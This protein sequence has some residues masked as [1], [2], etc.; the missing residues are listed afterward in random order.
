MGAKMFRLINRK[1]KLA[2]SM[3]RQPHYGYMNLN[4][5]LMKFAFKYACSSERN[6]NGQAGYICGR[7]IAM[8]SGNVLCSIRRISNGPQ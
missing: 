8:R 4:C 5:R 3:R 6:L 7:V 2:F 1:D